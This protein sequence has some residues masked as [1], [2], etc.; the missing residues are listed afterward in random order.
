MMLSPALFC[1]PWLSEKPSESHEEP[2]LDSEL[3]PARIPARCA[4]ELVLLR[5]ATQSVPVGGEQ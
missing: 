1:N 2:H 3:K 4:L 5:V